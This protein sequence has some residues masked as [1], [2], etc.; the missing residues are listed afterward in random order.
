MSTV[1]DD[2]RDT[3]SARIAAQW[4]DD[5]I[6]WP[7]VAYSP[8]EGKTWLSVNILWGDG[9]IATKNGRNNLVGVLFLTVF[10]PVGRGDGAI[11][12]LAD[13]ARDMVNRLEVSGVRFAAPSGPSFSTE[14]ATKWRQAQVTCSFSVEEEV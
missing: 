1:V 11:S 6:R 10:S 3:I 8:E 4:A 9:F 7:N 2:T 12:E 14:T 5:R 13:D